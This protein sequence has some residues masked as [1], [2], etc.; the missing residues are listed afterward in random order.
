DAP[1]LIV[2]VVRVLPDVENEE[3]HLA[4]RDGR[5]GVRRDLDFET[6]VVDQPHPAAAE[7]THGGCLELLAEALFPAEVRI[8]APRQ[9][10][11]GSCASN[12]RPER[13]PV[14]GMVPCLCGVV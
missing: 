4:V 1:G 14:E 10:A 2:E 8:D 6:A 9:R 12:L 7:N 5:V 13:A 11:L 3:R